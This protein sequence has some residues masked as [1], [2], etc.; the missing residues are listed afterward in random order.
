[1]NG[2]LRDD[3]PFPA[4]TFGYG[5]RVCPGRYFAEDILFLAIASILAVFTIEREDKDG[6]KMPTEVKEELFTRYVLR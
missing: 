1:M 3:V 5:R 2:Q 4:E 6:Y